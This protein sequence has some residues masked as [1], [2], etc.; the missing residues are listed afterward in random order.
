MELIQHLKQLTT[1]MAVDANGE[2]R[3]MII[4]T[5]EEIQKSLLVLFEAYKA[6][7]VHQADLTIKTEGP[8]NVYTRAANGV[9]SATVWNTAPG[10]VRD[11]QVFQQ[12]PPQPRQGSARKP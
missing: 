2:P 9:I 4:C 1:L 7:E 11:Y 10:P 12:C 5:P 6:A 3:S 8:W